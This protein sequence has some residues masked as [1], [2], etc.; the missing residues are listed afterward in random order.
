M[1]SINFACKNKWDIWY[2]SL[3]MIT[4][5]KFSC[6]KE[7]QS[8]ENNH[9]NTKAKQKIIKIKTKKTKKKPKPKCLRNNY[10][11]KKLSLKKIVPFK[12]SCHR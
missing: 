3:G 2:I 6:E 11:S 12:Y 9:T 5:I 8:N 10:H 4:E 7:N 1:K